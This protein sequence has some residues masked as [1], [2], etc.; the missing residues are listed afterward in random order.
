RVGPAPLS[1]P[2]RERLRNY[3]GTITGDTEFDQSGQYTIDGPLTVASGV[4]LTIGKVGVNVNLLIKD[5]KTL[6][7][8]GTLSITSAASFAIED[9]QSFASEGIVVNGTLAVS[10]SSL[11]RAGGTNQSD[12]SRVLVNAGGSLVTLTLHVRAAAPAGPAALN[13]VTAVN[14]TGVRVYRTEVDDDQGAFVLHPLVTDGDDPGVDGQVTIAV[15][16]PPAE[17]PVAGGAVPG[18]PQTIFLSPSVPP[19]VPAAVDGGAPA[20]PAESV[21]RNRTQREAGTGL[22]T[23]AEAALVR[24][25]LPDRDGRP[26][27]PGAPP[28]SAPT[29]PMATG[30]R[31]LALL[32]SAGVNQPD[33]VSEEFL[34]SLWQ[35]APDATPEEIGLDGLE[36][37]FTRVAA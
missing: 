16:T 15:P 1:T 33:G 35:T 30:L 2:T 25:A 19:A 28:N 5:G 9:S 20:L 36:A 7:V 3:N 12:T 11:T 32:L 10:N 13:L 37:F 14:P 26:G 31:D 17:A 23:M 34:A 8:N 29:G 18:S 24:A 21:S 4:T 27:P 22:A 6:T